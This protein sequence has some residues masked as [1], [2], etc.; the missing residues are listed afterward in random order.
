MELSNIVILH[1]AIAL[2]ILAAAEIIFFRKEHFFECHKKD[3]LASLCLGIG[4]VLVGSL[5]KGTIVIFIQ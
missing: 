1:G 5:A 2:I 4:S 3:M